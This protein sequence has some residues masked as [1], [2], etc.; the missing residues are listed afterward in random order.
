[1]DSKTGGS[2]SGLVDWIRPLEKLAENRW[3]SQPCLESMVDCQK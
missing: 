3:G 1:M 2:Q